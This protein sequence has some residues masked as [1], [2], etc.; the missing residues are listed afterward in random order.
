MTTHM[1]KKDLA[2]GLHSSAT[3]GRRE[4]VRRDSQLRLS[5]DAGYPGDVAVDFSS[6]LPCSRVQ[7]PPLV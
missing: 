4:S 1:Q 6:E 5:E 2:D 7:N 3:E